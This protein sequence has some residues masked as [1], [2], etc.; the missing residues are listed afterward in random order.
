MELGTMCH[1]SSVLSISLD[2][3]LEAFTLG[4]S[5]CVNLIA[6]REDVSLNLIFY[7]ILFS[8]LKLEFSYIS[9]VR[10]ASLIKMTFLWLADQFVP[11][12]N[13]TNLHCFVTIVLSRLNLCYHTGSCLKYGYRN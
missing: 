3:A 4:N 1:R 5:G 7:G 8:I 11:L 9:L 10:N 12:V 13:K 2:G 6:C